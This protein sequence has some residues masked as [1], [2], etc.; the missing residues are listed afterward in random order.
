MKQ[1][2]SIVNLENEEFDGEL[3]FSIVSHELTADCCS[4]VLGAQDDGAVVGFKIEIPIIT[5]KMA[6][7]SYQLICPAGTLKLQSIGEKSDAFV[8][9]FKKFFTPS[10]DVSDSFCDD[11]VEVDYVL[12]NKGA[13]DLNQDKIYL[14]MFYDET[15]DEDLPKNERV[16]FNMSFTFNLSRESASL[17]E[18]ETGYS[19]DFL[20]YIMK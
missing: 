4:M 12:Q 11:I 13:Y 1:C 10:Y 16:R 3:C 14:R 17:I 15:L 6:F 18:R 2:V 9:T 20:C 8:R 19:A 7:R 5:K